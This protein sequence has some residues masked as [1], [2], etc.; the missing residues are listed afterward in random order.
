MTKEELMVGAVS[1]V[2]TCALIGLRQLIVRGRKSGGVLIMRLD[3]DGGDSGA[4][5]PSDDWPSEIAI[6]EESTSGGQVSSEGTTT[7]ARAGILS[8]LVLLSLCG[9][10]EAARAQQTIFNVPSTDV[11]DRGKVYAELD[12]AFKP[13]DSEALGRFS[14]FVPRVVVGAG[15][16]VEVGLNVTGNV[17]PGP[18]ATT[19]VPVI[20][21]KFYD[22]KD[23]GFAI[24][25]GD[26]L[27]APVR[28]RAYNAGNYVYLEFS[29]TF[30]QSGTRLTAGGYDFTR[31]VVANANRAGG[32]F[33]FEQPVGKKV[34]LAADYF[35][36][37]HAAGYFTPG[38]VFR[39]GP[40]LTGYAGYS[41]GN[42][43]PSRGNHFFLLE[44]GYNFN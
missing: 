28:N 35:T 5:D 37:K 31:S 21:Y 9:A 12:A 43:N 44:L 26:H 19:L 14:S 25:G 41:I 16:R 10:S 30:K 15:G 3:R 13:N 20:K 2:F 7:V 36:G 24:V 42:Q 32:Q 40:K 1:L 23:N 22:G 34:T 29:K 6:T 38:A 8:A 18:D 39:V 27:F 33:G 17:Q 11:L 4:D